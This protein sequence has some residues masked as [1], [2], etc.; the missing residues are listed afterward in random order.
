MY[1]YNYRPKF[2]ENNLRSV[3]DRMSTADARSFQMDIKLID[4]HE[5]LRRMYFGVR[6][7]FL[8]EDPSNIPLAKKR[9]RRMFII[10]T[11]V[12]QSFLWFSLYYLCTT[13]MN[14]VMIRFHL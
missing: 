9:M 13:L 12:K 1:F 14:F 8:K 5:Y 2:I 10:N 6:L 4:W 11:I 7:Y 3:I